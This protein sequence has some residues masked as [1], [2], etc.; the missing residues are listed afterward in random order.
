MQFVGPASSDAFVLEPR[1]AKHFGNNKFCLRMRRKLVDA[2]TA[3][4]DVSE[5]LG[6]FQEQGAIEGYRRMPLWCMLA[7]V[8]VFPSNHLHNY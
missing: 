4:T 2:Q 1:Q 7:V 5:E 8:R 6:K 3:L